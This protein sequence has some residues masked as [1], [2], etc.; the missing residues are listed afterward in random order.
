MFQNILLTVHVNKINPK[1]TPE[2]SMSVD[3]NQDLQLQ[4]FVVC[5]RD[6]L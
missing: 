5:L 4:N 2:M 3:A 6:N 1:L